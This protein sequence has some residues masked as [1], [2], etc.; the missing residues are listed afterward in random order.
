MSE[1]LRVFYALELLADVRERVA[2]HIA[3]LRVDAPHIKANWERAEKL[4]VTLKFF[5]EIKTECIEALQNAAERAVIGV[6]PFELT[7]KEAGV[8][9]PRRAPRVFWLGITDNSDRLAQL[10]RRLEDE[11]ER[12]K[13]PREQRPFHPHITIARLHTPD[14]RGRD[15]AQLHIDL[16]FE[17]ITFPVREIVIMR[18]ELSPQG[19]RYITLSRHRLRI[20]V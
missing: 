10:Q 11:A 17:P 3:R 2:Q 15:L 18:S 7:L 14:A 13:F 5:G 12:E 6:A 8:F 16:G 9:P 20:E 4:H 19:S 1:R